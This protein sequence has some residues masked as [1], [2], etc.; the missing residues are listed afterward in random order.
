MPGRRGKQSCMLVPEIQPSSLPRPL[1]SLDSPPR[2]EVH[3]A[4]I[5]TCLHMPRSTR[6]ATHRSTPHSHSTRM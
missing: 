1:S 3:P 4:R 2:R 6:S 5:T